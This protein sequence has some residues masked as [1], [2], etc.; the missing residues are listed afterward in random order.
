M[1]NFLFLFC[2]LLGFVLI[3]IL[4]F[5]TFVDIRPDS[6]LPFIISL[7]GFAAHYP[8]TYHHILFP[9]I[10]GYYLQICGCSFY[11]SSRGRSAFFGLLGLLSPVGYIFLAALKPAP[12]ILSENMACEDGLLEGEVDSEE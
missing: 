4:T 8:N 1:K 10:L 3:G 12:E 11:A 9:V 7:W 6:G 5:A 2:S